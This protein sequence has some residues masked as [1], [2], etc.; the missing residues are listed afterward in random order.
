MC[1]NSIEERISNLIKSKT[2]LFEEVVAP[3]ETIIRQLGRDE[4]AD[5]LDLDL[6]GS[7]D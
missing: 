7:A 5:L 1:R 3:T 6:G 4:L 2:D